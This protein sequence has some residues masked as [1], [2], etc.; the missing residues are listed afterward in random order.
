MPIEGTVL[1]AHADQMA[2]LVPAGVRL[3]NL[4]IRLVPPAPPADGKVRDYIRAMCELQGFTGL[5]RSVTHWSFLG[6][7]RVWM[8]PESGVHLYFRDEPSLFLAVSVLTDRPFPEF[9][10]VVL[11]GDHFGATLENIAYFSY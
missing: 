8:H 3:Q 6:G 2:A 10:A 9:D 1:A 11:T 7:P 4:A 5:T